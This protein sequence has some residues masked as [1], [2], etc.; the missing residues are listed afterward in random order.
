[1]DKY[2]NILP[3]TS[4]DMILMDGY[5]WYS[6]TSF[7]GLCCADIITGETKIIGT[8]LGEEPQKKCLHGCMGYY[9]GKLIFAPNFSNGI[10]IYDIKSGKFDRIALPDKIVKMYSRHSK[11][12]AIQQ[13][14]NRFIMLGVYM[15]LIIYYNALT[16]GVEYIYNIGEKLY[17]EL[18]KREVNVFRRTTCRVGR[19]MYALCAQSGDIIEIDMLNNGKYEMHQVKNKTFDTICHDGD[20]F[21]L[22]AYN[23][24]Y[25]VK[26]GKVK[27]VVSVEADYKFSFCKVIGEYIYYMSFEKPELIAIQRNNYNVKK[28]VLP[29]KEEVL[30]INAGRMCSIYNGICKETYVDRGIVFGNKSNTIFFIEDGRIEKTNTLFLKEYDAELV[31]IIRQFLQESMDSEIAYEGNLNFWLCYL[32]GAED[33]C[34]KGRTRYEYDGERIYREIVKI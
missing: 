13:L 24:I 26:D 25:K 10:D 1:M 9:E 33:G 34:N 21:W 11:T 16:G 23:N 19:H 32:L 17:G 28:L 15:P 3:L 20:S 30:Q 29:D 27:K 14:E 6:A 8:F 18:Y 12:C 4:S 31:N 5:L 7:N 2:I 22:S